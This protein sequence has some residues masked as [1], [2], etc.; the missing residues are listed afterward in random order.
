[1]A[2]TIAMDYLHKSYLYIVVALMTYERVAVASKLLELGRA[3]PTSWC[4]YFVFKSISIPSD[5]DG[6]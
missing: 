6:F 2:T 4:F 3:C 1:M 5:F